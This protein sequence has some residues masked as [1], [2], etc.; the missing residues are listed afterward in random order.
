[1][2]S[3]KTYRVFGEDRV[4]SRSVATFRDILDVEKKQS[5]IRNDFKK[6]LENDQNEFDDL[7]L[8]EIEEQL[9]NIR[10]DYLA[11][12]LNMSTKS[13]ENED[14]KDINDFY[15]V[16]YYYLSTK[17]DQNAEAGDPEKALKSMTRFGK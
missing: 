3:E 15:N 12:L 6:D 2:A 14:P 7:K 10:V 1:M 11:G 5:K 17:E 4:I 9:F 8:M 13:F 16:I